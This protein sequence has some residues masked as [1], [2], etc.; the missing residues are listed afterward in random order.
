MLAP[1][2]RI[3]EVLLGAADY[4]EQHGWCQGMGRNGEAV[5]VAV[6]LK[7]VAGYRIFIAEEAGRRLARSLGIGLYRYSIP[8]W[9]DEPG[10]TQ[11]EVVEALRNVAF[12]PAG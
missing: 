12:A 5:C 3:T 9:N 7:I 1:R 10:R 11:V 2:D 8:C 6:A 4:I